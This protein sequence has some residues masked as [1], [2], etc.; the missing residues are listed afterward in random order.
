M[1]YPQACSW[2][3]GS[4]FD[5]EGHRQSTGFGA[6]RCR[7]AAASGRLGAKRSDPAGDLS[8]IEALVNVEGSECRTIVRTFRLLPRPS[9]YAVPNSLPFAIGRSKINS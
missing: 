4:P 6:A 7:A 8:K 5:Y 3:F 2:P 9:R 1:G